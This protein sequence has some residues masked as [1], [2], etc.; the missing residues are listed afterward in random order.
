MRSRDQRQ[1]TPPGSLIF[2]ARLEEHTDIEE[3]IEQARGARVLSDKQRADRAS[4]MRH[5]KIQVFA[6]VAMVGEK[7]SDGVSGCSRALAAEVGH[8]MLRTMLQSADRSPASEVRCVAVTQL[9]LACVQEQL[10]LATS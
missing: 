9:Q 8:T 5:M 7:I 10:C 4:L 3:T 1:S 6:E 2:V